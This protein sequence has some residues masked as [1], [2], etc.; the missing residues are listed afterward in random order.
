VP[1]FAIDLPE[2]GG[3]VALQAQYCCDN[4][5]PSVVDGHMIEY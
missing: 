2:G 1:T 4:K 5:Y 3:K